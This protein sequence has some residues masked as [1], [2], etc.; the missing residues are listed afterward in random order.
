MQRH[1]ANEEKFQ[2][3]VKSGEISYE[4]TRID[5]NASLPIQQA[6]TFR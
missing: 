4:L 6:A 3:A 2:I 1:K 5:T